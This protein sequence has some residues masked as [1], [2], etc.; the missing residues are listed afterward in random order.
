ML[1]LGQ[2]QAKS[3]LGTRASE[4]GLSCV[5]P[6]HCSCLNVPTSFSPTGCTLWGQQRWTSRKKWIIR[7]IIWLMAP[8]GIF[9]ISFILFPTLTITIPV[10]VGMQVGMER[11]HSLC[12]CGCGCGC[13]F[14]CVCVCG[15]VCGCGCMC[16]MCVCGCGVGVCVGVVWVCGWVWVSFWY[17]IF[18]CK[19]LTSIS[20]IQTSVQEQM[21]L[22]FG[23]IAGGHHIQ[24]IVSVYQPPCFNHH[25]SRGIRVYLWADASTPHLDVL[26]WTQGQNKSGGGAEKAQGGRPGDRGG[27]NCID[28][29]CVCVYVQV[30]TFSICT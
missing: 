12:V 10:L 15:S 14:V 19:V 3:G 9:L 22:Y 24:F 28:T 30:D 11:P 29:V 4:S 26:C 25:C 8:L 23:H 6:G 1:F 7:T 20:D 13:V 2:N 17:T 16:V 18:I 5:H 27:G 21:A